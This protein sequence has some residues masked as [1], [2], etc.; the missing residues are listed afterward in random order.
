[1][2]TASTP[3]LHEGQVKWYSVANGYGFLSPDQALSTA[4]GEV[5]TDVFVHHS[6]VGEREDLVPGERVLFAIEEGPKG[7]LATRL[8][9]VE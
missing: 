9:R 7:L 2:G 5:A 1:M 3:V 6:V 8:E 4:D